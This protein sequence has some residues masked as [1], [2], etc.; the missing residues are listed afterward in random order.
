[1]CIMDRLLTVYAEIEAQENGATGS[2]LQLLYYTRH[3][4]RAKKFVWRFRCL[5]YVYTY[6]YVYIS[7]LS[8]RVSLVAVECPRLRQKKHI[9]SI[10]SGIIG[11]FSA[12]VRCRLQ[13]AGCFLQV[14]SCQL[15]RKL[16]SKRKQQKLLTLT[17]NLEE[18]QKKQS[19]HFFLKISPRQWDL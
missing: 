14:Y 2:C 12:I 15:Q 8:P 19:N 17:N 3:H 4:K 16:A 11:V 18:C 9:K 6:I 13:V 7:F 10:S 5:R 1:M